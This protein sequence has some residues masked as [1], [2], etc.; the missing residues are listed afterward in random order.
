MEFTI[1]TKTNKKQR[2]RKLVLSKYTQE[3]TTT[4]TFAL[5][6]HLFLMKTASKLGTGKKKKSA[7]SDNPNPG[8]DLMHNASNSV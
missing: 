8:K 2:K 5:S 7:V 4:K 3:K 1:L 6:Q